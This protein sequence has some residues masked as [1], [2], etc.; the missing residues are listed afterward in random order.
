MKAIK[1]FESACSS[2]TP[3]FSCKSKSPPLLSAPPR[4]CELAHSRRRRQ[5]VPAELSEIPC[6]VASGGGS[7]RPPSARRR[8]NRFRP[9][10][11][12]RLRTLRRREG[13]GR[14][15]TRE[16]RPEPSATASSIWKAGYAGPGPRSGSF[17][18]PGRRGGPAAWPP[19]ARPIYR[20]GRRARC[21]SSGATT[22]TGRSVT[23]ATDATSRTAA[24]RKESEGRY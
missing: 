19:P 1:L 18:G 9:P 16:P 17:Q 13:V 20:K 4:S 14:W 5:P 21:E 10:H 23:R 8:A 15:W 12:S 24:R 6:L 7:V 11:R 3:L 2:P 22:I